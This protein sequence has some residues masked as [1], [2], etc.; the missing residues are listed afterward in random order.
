MIT[1]SSSSVFNLFY[2]KLKIGT[3]SENNGGW[4]FVYS[5]EFKNQN[6]ISPLIGFNDKN[7]IYES[8][9]LWAFFDSRIPSLNNPD[10]IAV[11]KAK[12][13][14]RNNRVLLLRKFGRRTVN[15]PF[16]LI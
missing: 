9:S 16:V 6:R 8:N 1:K 12:K 2:G 5:E 10:T 4:V 13:I 15:N 14:D 7:T 11:I 3:L